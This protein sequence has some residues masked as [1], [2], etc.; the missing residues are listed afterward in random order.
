MRGRTA[1]GIIEHQATPINDFDGTGGEWR[2]FARCYADIRPLRGRE[3]FDAQ[4][5]QSQ[6]THNIETEFISGVTSAMR[7]KFAKTEQVNQNEENADE[8]F[9]IFEIGSAINVNEANRSLEL[10]CVEKT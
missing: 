10:L 4:Q 8:N 9:R 5:V 2:E 7:I 6:V 1:L 3:L